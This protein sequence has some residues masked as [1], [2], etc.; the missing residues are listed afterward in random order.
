[1]CRERIITY[2]RCGH[3]GSEKKYC[4]AAE[5]EIARVQKRATWCCFK[6][7]S[8]KIVCEVEYK[9]YREPGICDHCKAVHRRE[10]AQ[11]VRAFR[12]EAQRKAKAEVDRQVRNRQWQTLVEDNEAREKARQAAVEYTW[13]ARAAQ[14]DHGDSFIEDSLYGQVLGLLSGPEY[15]EYM[16]PPP[17]AALKDTRS[18]RELSSS[19]LQRRAPAS[20]PAPAPAPPSA[21]PIARVS[22]MATHRRQM[23]GAGEPPRHVGHNEKED[24]SSRLAQDGGIPVPSRKQEHATMGDYGDPMPD[25]DFLDFVERYA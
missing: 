23:A 9:L 25:D 17:S 7:P 14:H 6:P 3:E 21:R 19:N 5:R 11:Q 13:R 16:L 24:S 1:M 12:G 8:R 10:R 18:N 15:H 20:A 2:E 4:L 22:A